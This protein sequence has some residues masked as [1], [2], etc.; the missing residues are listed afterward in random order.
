VFDYANP[1]RAPNSFSANPDLKAV[2]K[3]PTVYL[4]K[5]AATVGDYSTT[6]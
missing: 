1:P 4:R 6:S 5:L 3:S 2:A